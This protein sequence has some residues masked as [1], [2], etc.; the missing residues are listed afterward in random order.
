MVTFFFAFFF[1]VGGGLIKVLQYTRTKLL[2]IFYPF[3]INGQ[4]AG[5]CENT[6]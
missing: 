5:H 1:G 4:Y 3:S 2:G 6:P